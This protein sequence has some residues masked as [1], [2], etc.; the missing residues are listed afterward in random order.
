MLT[1]ADFVDDN[2]REH[3]LNGAPGEGNRPLSVFKDKYSEQ[4]AYPGIFLGQRPENKDRLLILYCSSDICKSE[5]R[6]SDRRAAMWVEN[7]FFQVKL[8]LGKSQTALRKCKGNNS[9]L[10]AGQLKQQG[11]LERLIHHDDN[12]FLRALRGSPP[13][14]EKSKERF[15][16]HD[17]TARSNNLVL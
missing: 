2:E 16:C 5:L 13:Y 15:I 10:T 11:S 4:L 8:L 12:K 6:Q 7:I 14:F 1:P 3:I 9:L 17:S